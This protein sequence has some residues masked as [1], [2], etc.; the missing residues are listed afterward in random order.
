MI[1]CC[2]PSGRIGAQIRFR[3]PVARNDADTRP[4]C[5]I[6]RCYN[7]CSAVLT[8]CWILSTKTATITRRLACMCARVNLSTTAASIY[9]NVQNL[10]AEEGG[11]ATSN[12]RGLG[13]RGWIQAQ[14]SVWWLASMRRIPRDGG[15]G[16]VVAG[17][18]GPAPAPKCRWRVSAAPTSVVLGSL[19]SV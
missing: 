12:P 7:W 6:G 1:L 13:R 16:W 2:L 10:I 18:E 5:L 15:N 8:Q 17:Q 9:S 19:S 14:R 4:R 11:R 3:T